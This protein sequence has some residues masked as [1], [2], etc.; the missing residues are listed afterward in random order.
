MV[1]R[2]YKYL[3]RPNRT[4]CELLESVLSQHRYIYNHALAQ[5]KDTF[6]Q[7]GQSISYVVQSK[8]FLDLRR[9]NPDVLGL[10]NSASVQQTLRKLDK[11]FTAFFRRLKKGESQ[12]GYPRF[13]GSERFNSIEYRYR[14]GCILKET[15]QNRMRLKVQ[16]I[17][18]IRMCYH[19][20]VPTGAVIKHSVIKRVNNKWYV[21]LMMDIPDREILN[22]N[23]LEVGIDVGI[24]CV[25]A[26]SDGVIYD[27]PKWLREAQRE[28]RVKQRIL[29]RRK[30]G[31]NR[32]EKARQEV[33]KL[34]EK[35]ANQRS[36]YLHKITREL[37]EQYGFIA[38]E[39]LSL[40]FMNKNRHLALSSYDAS[41]GAFR[42]YLT[43]KAE[44]AGVS[45][46]AVNPSY[47]SQVCSGCGCL[48][49]KKLS[50]RTHK[51]LDCGLE[52]DRDVNAAVNIL[53]KARNITLGQSVRDVTWTEFGSSV[54][55]EAVAL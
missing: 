16:N 13:K 17:G 3:L 37:V 42:S 2:T 24:K 51:C 11:A 10:T 41:L 6:E 29:S 28:L 45:L 39:N 7:T 26:T 18:E 46:V 27:N 54:S 25:A 49:P 21:C 48:V 15:E 14:D 44:Y 38:I 5:R 35:I 22:T 8:Y 20:P 53:T 12:V 31:S 43:Y 4:Q 32:R 40:G 33:A 55:R 30:R 9:S 36:D 19:R 23:K 1:T 52:L 34:H 47:T 50:V